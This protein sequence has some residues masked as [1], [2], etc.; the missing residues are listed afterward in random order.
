MWQEIDSWLSGLQ[1]HTAGSYP[2]FLFTGTTKP[3]SSWLRSL[4]SSPSLYS[5]LG[6]P[7]PR[8]NTLR[9]ALLNFMLFARAQLS[10]LPTSLCMASLPFSMSTTLH[11][12]ISHTNQLSMHSIP[13]SMLLTEVLTNSVQGI[14][15]RWFQWKLFNIHYTSL[16]HLTS[17]KRKIM[18]FSS[19]EKPAFTVWN[20]SHCTKKNC[21]IV[22]MGLLYTGHLWKQGHMRQA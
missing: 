19:A 18:Q 12:S 1:M 17:K 10:S 20:I 2:S 13:L 16:G 9:L 5:C 14:K 22:T 21:E 7:Q 15:E 11:N 6:L 8:C 4:S 3:L